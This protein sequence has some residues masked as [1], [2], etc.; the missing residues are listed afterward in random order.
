L[1]VCCARSLIGV[2]AMAAGTAVSASA[3]GLGWAARTLP[4]HK[5]L[6]LHA[7][8]FLVWTLGV[9][10]ITWVVVSRMMEKSANSSDEYFAG[11]RSLKWYAVA[12]SL[13]LTNLSTEQLVGLNGAVFK[14]GCLSGIWWEA[15][16]AIA[17]LIT[18][19]VFLPKYF[20]L[21]LTTT[22]GFLGKRFDLNMRTLVSIIFLVYYALVLCPLVLYTGALAIRKIF[23]LDQVPLWVISTVIGSIGSL[24]ALFGG[25]KAVVVS[26][27]LNGLG[28]A[29][30]GLWV[31]IV[32]VTYLP[33]GISTLFSE[34]DLLKPLVGTSQVYNE[35]LGM[36]IAAAPSVPWHVTLTG[37]ALNNMYFWSTN[38]V[39]MQ[40]VLGAQSLAHGQKGVLFAACMKVCGFAFLCLPGIIGMLMVR[41]GVVVNGQTFTVSR[42][43]EVYPE[44]VKRIMPT[45]SLG[46]FSAILIGSV[47]STFNSALNASATMFGLEIYKVYF[48]KEASDERI[49]R[50]S[51][52]FGA[53][54]TIFSF[55][56]A[57]QLESVGGIYEY[58]QKM[59]TIVSLPILTVFFVGIASKMPDAFA[60]KIAFAAGI[61]TG[62]GGQ[63]VEMHYLHV[64]FF[65]FLIGVAVMA[66][67][68]YV[69]LARKLF[70]VDPHPKPYGELQGEAVVDVTPWRYLNRMVFCV[71]T[72]LVTL[73]VALQ[74]GE[75]WMFYSFWAIW[76]TVFVSL[77]A[78][79]ASTSI[80][81]AKMDLEDNEPNPLSVA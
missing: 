6:V 66:I 8:T 29:L 64:F 21:G 62:V 53:L 51:T 37:M 47:L 79:R 12:G 4:G 76:L 40:R 11:G 54:L 73:V 71:L 43:D 81:P 35:T 44:L 74:V 75:A 18:A 10:A 17:M 30:V 25:L 49:V 24:Y 77:M 31:P 46:L 42:P 13:M 23:E 52:V 60:A 48:D 2:R 41:N 59:N 63:Y 27:C 16:A 69:P 45:W 19:T 80:A 20:A 39:I 61:I 33:D 3:I 9:A 26:D 56:L 57:P 22:T 36:R 7:C 67:M 15:G 78:H 32:A 34:P 58:L 70:C 50:M 68:T 5:D 1:R 38:Q 65:N 28:L 55:F 72:I 14:D